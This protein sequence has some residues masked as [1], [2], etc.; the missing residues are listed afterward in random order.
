MNCTI[1][2][3]NIKV[4]SKLINALSKIGD[5]VY[6]EAKKD[7]LSLKSVNMTTTAYCTVHLR[8]T[9]FSSYEVS[10][11][12]LQCR[13]PVKGMLSVF[14]SF[15]HKDKKM[16]FCKIELEEDPVK[17][18]FRFKYKHDV[19]VV[20]ALF[21]SDGEAVNIVY[22]KDNNTSYLGATA[23]LFGQVLC[24]FQLHDDDMSL[25]VTSQRALIR[26]YITGDTAVTKGVRSQITLMAGEFS[27]FKITRDT[28]IT[29]SLK[30]FRAAVSLAE[31]TTLGMLLN[32]DAPG[33][34][35]LIEVKNPTFEVNFVIATLKSNDVPSTLTSSAVPIMNDVNWEDFTDPMDL[36]EKENGDVIT[37]SP[38]STHSTKI[39]RIFGRCYEDTFH[40]QMADLGEVLAP[41][42]DPDTD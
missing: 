14:K 1:P 42:S 32:F 7:Y 39:R 28:N 11:I 8:D 33:R 22:N 27:S 40:P 12:D 36:P 18:V 31:T 41:D 38:E 10:Q 16:E 5:D 26:N 3:P 6:V 30:P 2:G 24:N 23:Q 19:M 25:D 9:F 29:F 34:P 37:R 21:L 20:R 35:A 13:I 17:I 15:S 4:L